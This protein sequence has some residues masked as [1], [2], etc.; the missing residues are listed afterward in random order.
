MYTMQEV[1]FHNMAP[2]RISAEA[3]KQTRHQSKKQFCKDFQETIAK[4]QQQGHLIILG[5]DF[6]EALNIPNLGML[7]VTT[8]CNLV[9]P[10]I[11]RLPDWGECATQISGTKRINFALISPQLILAV[12]TIG[13][14]PYKATF[15]NSDHCCVVINFNTSMMFDDNHKRLEPPS[16]HSTNN[17]LYQTVRRTC[18]TRIS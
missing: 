12:V 1:R 4:L 5:G 15:M 6:N 9:D 11:Q 13:Y 10:W 7:Q 14:L 2:T 18:E 3:A 17:C 16:M 8:N